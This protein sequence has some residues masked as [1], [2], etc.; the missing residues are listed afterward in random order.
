MWMSSHHLK[1]NPSK[2][3]LLYHQGLTSP[4]N[5]LSISFENS[6]VTPSAEARSLD[7]ARFR[8]GREDILFISNLP[9][10]HLESATLRSQALTVEEQVLIALRFYASG[11]F[12]QVIGDGMCVTKS[13]VC[14]VIHRVSSALSR[15]LNQFV[16]FPE[17]PEQLN[18][19]KQDFFSLSKMPN[20]IGVIDCTHVYIQAPHE[21][22]WEFVN[23]KG[24]HSIN[25]QLVGD[26]DLIVTNCVESNFFKNFQQKPSSG[27]ILGDSGYPLLTWLMTPFATVNT[28]SELSFNRAHATARGTIERL[29]GVLKRRFACLNYLRVEP[30]Q[31][32]NICACIVLHNIARARKVPLYNDGQSALPQPQDAGFNMKQP[33]L[34]P[35]GLAGR[36]MRNVLQNAEEMEGTHSGRDRGE[37]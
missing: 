24:R 6:L 25:V 16:A 11:A 36:A 20:T 4:H 13:T 1:L 32:C 7:D 14:T 27:I 3:D 21:R 37:G 5:N 23:R 30:K 12:Y 8:F 18:K 33:P 28:D 2:T 29:N 19:I 15:L 34:Q 17:N 10:S 26:A 31:A 22:E 35:D 9:R